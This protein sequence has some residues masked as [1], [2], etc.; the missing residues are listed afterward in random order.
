MWLNGAKL[1]AS[2]LQEKAQDDD[3]LKG[4]IPSVTPKKT[5]TDAFLFR[6]DHTSDTET[7]YHVLRCP[8]VQ[9]CQGYGCP[10]IITV[11]CDSDDISF[12]N[13]HPRLLW[14]R[15]KTIGRGDQYCNFKYTLL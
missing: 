3:F 15:T 1:G 6:I 11:F 13:I 14:G 9:F 10:E 8:Y 2:F 7:E 4:W 12:G 5:E